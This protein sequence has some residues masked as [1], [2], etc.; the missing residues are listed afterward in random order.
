MSFNFFY[1]LK[2]ICSGYLGSDVASVFSARFYFFNF[3]VEL[4]EGQEGQV[5][6]CSHTMN[7]KLG[8]FYFSVLLA[9]W[10]EMPESLTLIKLIYFCLFL[11]KV[12]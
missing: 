12:L 1:A 8:Q 10:V 3:P 4:P 11:K 5:S 2:L 6:A 7:K 9:I